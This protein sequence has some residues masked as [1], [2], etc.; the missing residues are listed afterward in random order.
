MCNQAT[1]TD[2]EP[3]PKKLTT[4]RKPPFIR[5]FR[6]ACGRQAEAM[7]A[8]SQKNF[9]VSRVA[10][11]FSADRYSF[12]LCFGCP[13]NRIKHVKNRWLQRFLITHDWGLV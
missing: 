1:W 12:S 2:V 4:S 13:Q 8:G 6:Y 3:P 10:G 9:D 11:H 5:V 7:S